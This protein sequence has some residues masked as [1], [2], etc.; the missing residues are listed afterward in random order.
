MGASL[1]DAV[2]HWPE[3]GQPLTVDRGDAI[4]VLL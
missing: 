3:V 1:L 2:E 4:E